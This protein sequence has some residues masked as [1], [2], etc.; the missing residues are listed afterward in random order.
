MKK[1]YQKPQIE[2]YEIEMES[3]MTSLSSEDMEG[4]VGGGTTDEGAPDPGANRHRG[5]WGNLW[6]TD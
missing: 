1:T 3:Y 6:S 2:I 5:E 4:T